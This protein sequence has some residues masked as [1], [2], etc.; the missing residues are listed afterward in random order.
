MFGVELYAKI[1]RAV[2]V[3]GMSC[4]EAAKQFGVHRASLQ[5]RKQSKIAAFIVR[6]KPCPCLR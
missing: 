2:M 1:R 5:F 6:A 3:D 4:R